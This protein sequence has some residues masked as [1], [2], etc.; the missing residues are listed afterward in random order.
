M[1]V[2]IQ[3]MTEGGFARIV[4]PRLETTLLNFLKDAGVGMK[5][6]A[7]RKL[8]RSTI[9]PFFSDQRGSMITLTAVSMTAVMGFA[10]LGIDVAMWYAEK[11]STQSMADAAAV[12]ATY[13]IREGGDLTAV[14]NAART[15]AVRNG[16]TETSGNQL[17]VNNAPGTTVVGGVP[18]AEI[19]VT[20][21]VPVFLAGLFLEGNPSVSASS[22]GGVRSLGEICVVGLDPDA[23]RTVEFIGNA[24]A[25]LSCG[26]AS[27]SSSG[28]AL[29]VGGNATLIAN[30]AQSFGDIVVSGS[31]ELITE[32]PP[33]PFSPRVGDPFADRVFPTATGG[34]DFNTLTINSNTTIGPAVEGGSVRICG[35]L[36]V[37]P[38]RSLTL[39][40]GTY[41]V[42]G[43][44]ILFQGDVTG[45]EVTLVLT[46]ANASDVGEIDIR[47]QS[48]VS[49]T[50]PSS[51]VF[52]GIVVHQDAIAGES[53]DNKFNGGAT[54]ILIGAVHIPNQPL[55][56]NGG[57]DSV[58]CTK[59]V[60]RIVKF[61]GTSFLRN[62]PVLC[63]AV[64]LDTTSTSQDQVVLLQ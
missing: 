15:E 39:E 30:P 17:T 31:G 56:Y 28:D 40:A 45:D 58:G 8:L 27:D 53:G 51:G 23:G 2:M 55:T 6:S 1:S 22:L 54:M 46:G 5:R 57:A 38:N 16:F 11:R 32:L 20:R 3:L 13:A 35:D 4:R 26:V 12:A 44:D 59:I 33:M 48:Q 47:A 43:G 37:K 29:Y 50:A 10:G 62:T 34:C 49:L 61:S 7:F 25:N 21:Q 41:F 18:L 64:G 9:A 52:Q 19:T 60:A 42:D 14:E 36:T 24:F 63:Q